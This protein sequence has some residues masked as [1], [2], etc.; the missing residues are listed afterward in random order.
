MDSF[1]YMI[2]DERGRILAVRALSSDSM[3]VRQEAD[4]LDAFLNAIFEEDTYIGNKSYQHIRVGHLTERVSVVPA[5]LYAPSEA[6]TYLEQL[7]T[8]E[9]DAGIAAD[10]LD[11]LDVCLVYATRG[12]LQRRI[13]ERFPLA[14]HQHLLTALLKAWAAHAN[15]KER[16]IYI[17]VRNRSLRVAALAGSLLQFVNTFTF[18]D[19]RDFLYYVLLAYAQVNWKP[20]QVTAYA[21]GE[22]FEDSALYDQLMRYVPQVVFLNLPTGV[23]EGAAVRAHPPH[24]Y[25]DLQALLA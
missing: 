12:V 4:H 19:V 6:H 20:S 18:L 1:T 17:H 25:Y 8:L 9:S 11:E 7:T 5:R 13:E 23:A 3:P 22:L 24:F 21:C 14:Q 15:D 10:R 2:S 16:G